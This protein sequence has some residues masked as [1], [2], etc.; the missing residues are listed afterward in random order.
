MLSLRGD[1]E[2]EAQ[3]QRERDD[4]EARGYPAWA[5]DWFR[6]YRAKQ[7]RSFTIAERKAFYERVLSECRPEWNY[8]PI[9]IDATEMRIGEAVPP[10]YTSTQER[11]DRDAERLEYG[12]TKRFSE[13]P[14]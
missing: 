10:S 14:E 7:P 11:R 5:P 3:L 4:A 12:T 13:T 2:E 6:A 9:Y 1:P 8:G